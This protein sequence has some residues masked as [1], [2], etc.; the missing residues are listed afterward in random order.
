M[1]KLAFCKVYSSQVGVS[2]SAK[3]NKY[4]TTY[5][6][7]GWHKL[8]ISRWST[9]RALAEKRLLVNSNFNLLLLIRQAVHQ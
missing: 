1:R 4:I 3:L 8:S 6:G 2:I 5:R 9:L 7:G